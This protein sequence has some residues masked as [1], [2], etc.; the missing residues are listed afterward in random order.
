VTLTRNS[1]VHNVTIGMYLPVDH[2]IT[3]SKLPDHSHHN[4]QTSPGQAQFYKRESASV[5]VI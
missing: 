4:F 2:V 3:D 1:Y 5:R